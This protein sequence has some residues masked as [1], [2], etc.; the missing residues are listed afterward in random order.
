MHGRAHV[1]SAAGSLPLPAVTREVIR[2]WVAWQRRQPARGGGTYSLK[3]IANAH[4]LLSAVLARAAEAGVYL[5]SPKTRRGR[6]TVSLHDQVA[7]VLPDVVAGKA[8]G[9][10]MFTSVQSSRVQDQ[11]FRERVWHPAL[12]RAGIGK[13][14]RVH[15]LRHA[16]ATWM[17]AA[18]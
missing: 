16:H 5:G 14:P 6:R 7:R 10:L 3:S 17:I 11:H 18:A 8:P 2:G 12:V 4:G 15:D 1:G 9:E 13:T